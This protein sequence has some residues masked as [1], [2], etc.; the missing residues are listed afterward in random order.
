MALFDLFGIGQTPDYL[1]DLMSEEQRRK[2]Q[3]AASQNALLQAGLGMLAQSGYSRTPVTLGQ[4]LG[5]GGQ[6]GLGAYQGTMQQG[7][8]DVMMQQKIAEMKRQKEQELMQRNLTEQYIANLPLEQQALARAYPSIAQKMAERAALPP[9]KKFEKVG[10]TLLDVTAG[11]PTVAY[12]EPKEPTKQKYTGA[13]G[14]L[15]LSMFGTVNADDLTQQQRTDL[16]TEARKR[17]LERPPSISVTL[18]SESERT[19]G[20]LTSRLQ[21]GLNQLNQIITKNPN[22]AAPKLGAEAVKYLTGSDYLKNLTNTEDRQRIEAAQLEV[23]DSALTLGTGAAYTREQLENYRKSYFPQLG[24]RPETIK[25]KQKRLETLL[26]AAKSK[27][28]R[29]MPQGTRSSSDIYNQYND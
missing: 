23:L 16:D 15:A 20:F 27:S 9:E 21:G 6:A 13:Y 4:I 19:A 25:D 24:D 18:P 26:E 14:N 11:T 7:V 12:Q 8:Q 2:L 5:A 1:S 10:G 17:N 22:A 29:A 28:G 3:Q